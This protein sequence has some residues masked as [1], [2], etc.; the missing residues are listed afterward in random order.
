VFGLCLAQAFF[1]STFDTYEAGTE[2]GLGQFAHAAHTAVTQVIDVVGLATAV[3][4]LD[5]HLDGVK[6]VFVGTRE[7]AGHVVATTQTAVD[8]HAA[9]TRQIVS[10]F[11]VEQT[12]EQGFDSFFSWR[13]ARTHHAI[14]GDTRCHLVG[15]F[16]RT[17]GLRDIRAAIQVIGEQGLN[18]A[19]IGVADISQNRFRD[20]V[21]GVGNNFAGFRIDH[22]LG[23]HLSQDE[24]VGYRQV[25][26]LGGSHIA[27]MLG[28]DAFVFFDNDLAVAVGDVKARYFTF[29]A[30]GH[31]LEHG[32]V[33]FQLE[34]VEIEEMRQDGLGRHADG[35]E[36]N[37]YRHLATTVDTEEQNVLGVEF[38]VEP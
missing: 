1:H 22:V 11:A 29:P 25:F 10:F 7:G 26:D 9:D 30:L 8:L 34:I 21:V 24:V 17:Q 6:D 36:Q 23:Q 20:L 28:I 13:L 18:F 33:G 4:Q 12:L 5:Q 16:V 31:E 2:L 19:D 37:G 32:T 27:Q 3:T 35:L 15:S 38:E 14:D